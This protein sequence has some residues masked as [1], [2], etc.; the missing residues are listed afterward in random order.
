VRTNCDDL[1]DAFMT[2]DER[3]L[4]SEWPVTLA[5]VQVSVT[6]ASAMHLDQTFPRSELVWL[7]H[8]IVIP[9]RDGCVGRYDDSGLLGS[10]DVVRH[11]EKV[12]CR[13]RWGIIWNILY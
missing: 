11:L 10:W 9:D 3:E 7:L 8:R 5:G 1:A 12:S 13:V 6:Y 4:V 2:T